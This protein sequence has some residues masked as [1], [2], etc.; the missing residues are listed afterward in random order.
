M[1]MVLPA[2]AVA[3]DLLQPEPCGGSA[4]LGAP[5]RENFYANVTLPTQLDAAGDIIGNRQNRRFEQQT[6]PNPGEDES[7]DKCDRSRQNLHG[8]HA[9]SSRLRADCNFPRPSSSRPASPAR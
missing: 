5:K 8:G 4:G 3:R 1:L 6:N 2:G 9:N 7:G